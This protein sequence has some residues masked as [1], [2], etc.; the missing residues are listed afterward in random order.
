MQAVIKNLDCSQPF[1]S[2]VTQQEQIMPAAIKSIDC[3][4]ILTLINSIIMFKPGGGK[5]EEIKRDERQ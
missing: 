3:S 2:S 1:Y 4:T 5:M